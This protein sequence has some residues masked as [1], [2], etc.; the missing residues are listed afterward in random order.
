MVLAPFVFTR[1][2]DELQAVMFIAE[3]SVFKYQ[4]GVYSTTDSG[5]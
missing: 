1:V 4:L 3:M 2:F 5:P